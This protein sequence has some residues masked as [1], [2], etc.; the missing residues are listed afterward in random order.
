[1]NLKR[2]KC[3]WKNQPM[4]EWMLKA[5]HHSQE[6][7]GIPYGPFYFVRADKE[8]LSDDDSVDKHG[9][10]YGFSTHDPYFHG[11]EKETRLPSTP[12]TGAPVEDKINL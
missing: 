9:P 1:M 6:Q 4:S 2:R 8:G 11:D 3:F 12:K 5:F 7:Y 10:P